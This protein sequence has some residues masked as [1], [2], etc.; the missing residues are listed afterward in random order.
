MLIHYIHYN[1][2][3]GHELGML[4]VFVQEAIATRVAL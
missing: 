1:W 2:I 3:N 4:F